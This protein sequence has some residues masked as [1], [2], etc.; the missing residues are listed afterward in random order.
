M[1]N[2]WQKA[3]NASV[4]WLENDGNQK[5]KTWF[6]DRKPTHLTTVACGDLNGDGRDDIVAGVMKK[7]LKHEDRDGRV[8]LWLSG[9]N[10]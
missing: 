8:S 2:E 5:F 1:V 4:V 6:I 7:M 3:G 10:E 9:G